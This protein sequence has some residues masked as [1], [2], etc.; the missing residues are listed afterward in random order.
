MKKLLITCCLMSGLVSSAVLADARSDLQNRLNKVNS[1]HAS[2]SQSVKDA[3]GAAIQQGEGELWVKRPNLFRWHMASPDESILVS[4]G[5]TLW[6]F[7]P[8]VEQATVTW[9]DSVTGDTPFMLITRNSAT[10]WSKYNVQQQGDEFQ[11]TPKAIKGNLK[12]FS[13]NVTPDGIIK[14][15]VAVEQDGQRSSYALKGQQTG[16]VDAAQFTFTPPKGVT[17]DD[18]RK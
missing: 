10:D 9:L 12:A 8:F 17:I 13:I 6:F 1:F 18:Q 14:G 5:K 3:G 4:D 16:S 11:L 2:F 15:F 7:N